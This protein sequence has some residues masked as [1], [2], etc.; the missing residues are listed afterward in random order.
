MAKEFVEALTRRFPE[1]VIETHAHRGD[2]TVVI[3]RER[4]VEIFEWLKTSPDTDLNMLADVTAVDYLGKKTPRYEV[5]YH[6][7]SLARGK[8]LRVKVPLEAD[9]PIVDSVISVYESAD[10]F[11]REVWDMYGV[12]FEGHPNL[13]R[14][15]MY[16]E[17]DGHP[18]RKDYPIRRRQSLVPLKNPDA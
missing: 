1:E 8:R 14:I 11:E 10:W 16:E 7:T 12:R 2:D 6:L 15:L 4:V 18:L 5:V 17:F 9:D 13:K 3:K